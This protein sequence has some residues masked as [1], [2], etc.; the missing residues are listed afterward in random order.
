VTNA[1]ATIGNYTLTVVNPDG[2]TTAAGASF[3]VT[4]NQISA[5]SPSALTVPVSGTSTSTV[6]INGSGFEAGA[7]AS[8]GTCPGVTFVANS[9]SV[10]GDSSATFQVSV[11]AGTTPVQCGVTVTNTAPGNGASSVAVN[12]LGIGEAS[13]LSP[14][15]TSSSLSGSPGLVAGAPSSAIVFTGE[16]FSPYTTPLAYS[17]Y[18]TANTHDAHATISGCVAS[19]GTSL[20]CSVAAASNTVAGAHTALLENATASASLSNA[21]SVAG[22]TITSASPSGLA[23]GA[24]IGTTVALTGTGFTNTLLGTVGSGPLAGNFDYVSPTLVNFIVTTSPSIAD[25]SDTLSVYEVNTY[26][27]TTYSAPVTLSVGAAPSISSVTYP[28]GTSGVGV[29]ATSRAVTING[30]GLTAGATVTNFVSI[31]N[32]ADTHV[33]ATVTSVNTAGTQAT[34]SV[35]VTAGDTSAIDGYVLTNT[36]GGTVTVIPLAPAGL[37]L[38]AAPTITAVSP[39]T[40]PAASTNTFVVT[41]SGFV[42][43]AVA[44]LTATGT[45]APTTWMS[46]TSLSVV[47]TLGTSSSSP[48]ALVVTNPDGGSATSAAILAAKSVTPPPA[49]FKVSHVVGIAVHGRTMRLAVVGSGFVGAPTVTANASGVIVRDVSDNGTVLRILV[50]TPKNLRG[51]HT[52]TLRLKNGKTARVNYRTI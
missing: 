34:L 7:T 1:A 46:A 11:A 16:G 39:A 49:T 10:A 40:P 3:A 36:N 15:I 8:L 43:G 4:G 35:S 14:V 13:A 50:T 20:T 37:V 47:C 12:G 41:G 38:D 22:P 52:F 51:V 23:A 5:L 6:T 25:A 31:G 30:T 24:P 48:D 45:C 33:S 19:G 17:E 27:A 9:T 44:S 18:G 26:G 28:T 32:V 29:G 21:F 2:G 42:T